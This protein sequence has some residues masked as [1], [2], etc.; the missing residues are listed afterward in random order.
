M[1]CYLNS[2]VQ[3]LYM[4]PEFRNA[5]YKWEYRISGKPSTSAGEREAR[6][7][8]YQIQKL[9]LLLQTSDLSSLE[10]K[11]LTASF[12][13][14][15]SEAYDQHDV[16]ELCRL[17]FDALELKWKGT[18]NEKLIQSLYRLVVLQTLVFALFY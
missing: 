6:S 5:I 15:S 3:S 12:G 10:T 14:S 17:M 11:D 13:W 9:F 18:Q 4:T 2:L 1:T 7:I 16:Q 8:P